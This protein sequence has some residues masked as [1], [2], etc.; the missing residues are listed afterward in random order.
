MEIIGAGNTPGSVAMT[1]SEIE[2]Q[3]PKQSEDFKKYLLEN[4]MDVSE[5]DGRFYLDHPSVTSGV[6]TA[7]KADKFKINGKSRVLTYVDDAVTI[8]WRSDG[9]WDHID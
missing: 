6:F 2:I 5:A 3:F 4:E 1:L 7:E 9:Y 8:C